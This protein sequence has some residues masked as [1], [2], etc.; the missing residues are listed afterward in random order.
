M[1]DIKRK[2]YRTLGLGVA[3]AALLAASPLYAAD[4]KLVIVT[5]F[6]SDLTD[7]F[8]TAFMKENPSIAVE[9]VNKST[10]SGVKYLI[11]T[12]Q[13]NQ[14]DIFWASAPDAFEVL[15]GEELLGSYSKEVDGIPADL[16]G[17]P[18][19]DPDGQYLGFALSG[20]GFMW[21]T[22]YMDAYELPAP[23]E[24]DDLEKPVYHGHVGISSPSRSGTTH[25]TIETILQGEGWEEGWK[26]LKAISGNAKTITERSFGVPDGVN[27]GSF[28]VG[29]VIDFFGFSSKAS[30]FPVEFHYP[31]V[32][33]LVP[34]NIGVVANAPN[35]GP[36]Q[37]FIDFLLSEKGQALLFDPKIMRLPVNKNAYAGAPEGLPN[38]FDGSIETKVNFDSD[39]SEQ[40]YNVIN[41][42]FDVMI[43]YRLDDLRNATAAVQAA[44]TALAEAG[45]GNAE[46]AKLIEEAKALINAL[47]VSAEE[48]ADPDFNAIF[49]VKRK[50]ADTKV[51]GRQAEI[52]QQWDAMVVE[53]Y[54]KA[55][56]LAEKAKSLL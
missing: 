51:E 30:G 6:P 55:T 5:S 47:P 56:E 22:R 9:V 46:A 44:D 1:P 18:I 15:K 40:R 48:A 43:T 14:S 10:S 12:A 36:A 39:V 42:L 7:V 26:T 29:I 3:A 54:R 37:K 16:N 34:A 45:S 21:N 2:P 35:E 52:E 8:K 20:Y 41:S 49:T 13:N 23:K 25:L 11:E 53:N 19:N 4:D 31:S 33:A 28:G 24:W 27:S 17:Y 32:T 50:E 38:P